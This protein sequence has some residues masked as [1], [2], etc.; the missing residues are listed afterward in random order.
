MRNVPNMI[1]FA[2]LV[3]A[4]YVFILAYRGEEKESAVLFL[5]LAI[6]DAVDGTIARLF[7]AQT[8]LGKLVDPLADKMLLFF[9]LLSIT[10]YT[11]IKANSLLI[12]LL[13]SRDLFLVGGSL[14]LRRFGFMPEPSLAGKATT[15]VVSMTVFVG[16]MVNLYRV[17]AL[18]SA[19]EWLQA[20]SLALITVSALDYGF[21]GIG[22]LLSKFII[23]KR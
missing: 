6:S 7:K 14:V 15:F 11:D 23:E 18:L 10:I 2:R 4:P 17:P 1:S 16:F 21:R 3:L 9:G 20:L 5:I 22:F 12:Q 8:S 13:V 19:F